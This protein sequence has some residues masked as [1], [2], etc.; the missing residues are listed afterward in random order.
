[1]N[2]VSFQEHVNNGEFFN[3][4]TLSN[5]RV[6][7]FLLNDYSANSNN[8]NFNKFKSINSFFET[9]AE[10]FNNIF[11]YYHEVLNEDFF[12][13]RY[14]VTDINLVN[15]FVNY[16][17]SNGI[18]NSSNFDVIRN[19]DYNEA[20]LDV[21]KQ[22]G[23]VLP[24]RFLKNVITDFTNLEVS[25]IFNVR[26]NDDSS[27]IV[28]KN[29]PHNTYLTLKQ[30]RYKRKKNIPNRVQFKIDADGTKTKIVKRS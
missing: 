21:K 24:V 14:I 6:F 1:M 13:K 29:A 3:N 15:S 4:E 27:L 9:D 16:L 5:D 11:N 10:T 28:E 12:S 20:I 8:I 2:I 19:N 22:T 17:T 25:D 7:N 30:K 26:F 23:V 18:N